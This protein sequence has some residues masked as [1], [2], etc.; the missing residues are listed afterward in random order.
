MNA[1]P[2]RSGRG[3]TVARGGVLIVEGD[4][5]LI[6]GIGDQIGIRFDA[7]RN[8]LEAVTARI[9]ET[10]DPGGLLVL[11]TMFEDRGAAGPAYFVPLFND[12]E[13]TGMGPIDR[14]AEFGVARYEGVV[15]LKRRLTHGD[16]ILEAAVHELAHRHVAYL[17]PIASGTT[18]I[19]LLGRQGAHW[20]ALLHS[21][22]SL[23]GGHAF[24]PIG[25]DRFVV[26]ERDVRLSS[27]DLYLLGLA[28][29]AGVGPFF[30]IGGGSNEDGRPIPEAAELAPGVIVLGAR[31]DLTV[32]DVLS[33]VGPRSPGGAEQRLVFALIT[34]PG[35][36]ATS[37]SVIEEAAAIDRLRG[38]IAAA[39][40]DHTGGRACTSTEDC[41]LPDAGVD[42]RGRPGDRGGCGCRVLHDRRQR[43]GAG[44]A[45]FAPALLLAL[46]LMARTWLRCPGR[47]RSSD[48]CCPHGSPHRRGAPRHAS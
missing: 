47:G 28:A 40:A 14:R 11:F 5:E 4:A 38:D 12:T 1:R 46:G 2:E 10:S 33:S 35:E 43:E 23:L 7:E 37:T 25:P 48:R 39:W 3:L 42:D 17:P 13:G 29:P 26:L 45:R 41:A 21:E 9:A 18:A 24:R 19:D 15:N 6:S 36:V 20:H 16:R 44:R 8:D 32:E 27:L 34:R 22:G 31:I 30:F